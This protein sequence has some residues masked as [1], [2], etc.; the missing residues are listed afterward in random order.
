MKGDDRMLQKLIENKILVVIRYLTPEEALELSYILMEEDFRFIEVSF[1]DEWASET[2]KKLRDRFGDSIFL[3]A[4][5]VFD[6]ST[7]LKAIDCGVDYI[8]SPG[9]SLK[10]AEL[11]IKDKKP[12]IPGVF[13]P[14]DV[15][16][17]LQLGFDVLKLY[18]ADVNLLRSYRSP[19]PNVKFMPFGGI[20]AENITTYLKAGAAAVGI[21]N[22]IANKELLSRRE[23]LQVKDRVKK[24]KEL[25]TN[26]CGFG[27]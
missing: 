26:R 4:G 23:L 20:N 1:S 19:F 16:N 22:Y 10:V 6:E 24:V 13:T 5:T 17:A 14:T 27:C 11:A 8:L 15:Q 21:G 2:L 12:Y 9:L 7:Y 25:V 3:G 18:P